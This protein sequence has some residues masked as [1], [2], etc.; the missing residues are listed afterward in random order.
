M[1]KVSYFDTSIFLNCP[2]LNFYSF[3]VPIVYTTGISYKDNDG[4][5]STASIGV[6][7][8]DDDVLNRS[9]VVWQRVS[10]LA[11]YCY[12]QLRIPFDS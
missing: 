1:Y 5:S 9:K 8:G 7:W 4:V 2:L 12:Q 11:F 10:H 3:S 6:Y